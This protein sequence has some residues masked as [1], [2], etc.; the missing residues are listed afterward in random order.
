MS[1]DGSSG[2]MARY[3][4]ISKD[5]AANGAKNPHKSPSSDSVGLGFVL[6]LLLLRWFRR[7][8][9]T[10]THFCWGGP[11]KKNNS[12]ACVSLVSL[13]LVVFTTPIPLP[14]GEPADWCLPKLVTTTLKKHYQAP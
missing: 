5:K 7:E 2:G 12:M 8:E 9:R 11:L 1:R 14:L 4:V 10:T 13:A 6:R 3:L